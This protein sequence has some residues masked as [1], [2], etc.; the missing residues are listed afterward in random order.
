MLIKHLSHQL[1]D[2]E[3][4]PNNQLDLNNIGKRTFFLV[5]TIPLVEQQANVIEMQTNL[6]VGKF[7]G[8]EF[9]F[10]SKGQWIEEIKKYQVI[11]MI[12]EIFRLVIQH[13]FLPL[14]K[15]NLLIFDEAHHA[16][17][18]HPYREIMSYF[19]TCP[20]ENRPKILGLS[21]SLINSSISPDQLEEQIVKLEKTMRS[22]CDTSCD[23]ISLNKYAAKPKEVICYYQD[24]DVMD[25]SDEQIFDSINNIQALVDSDS[26]DN[27]DFFNKQVDV[28]KLKSIL[29]DV[30]F[31]LKSMGFWCGEKVAEFHIKELTDMNSNDISI[32]NY[33]ISCLTLFKNA[34]HNYL[35]TYDMRRKLIDFSSPKLRCLLNILKDYNESFE[36]QDDNLCAIIFVDRRSSS[37]ILTKWLFEISKVDPQY[38]FLKVEFVVGNSSSSLKIARSTLNNQKGI[39]EKFRTHQCNILAATSV[40]EEGL[41][42]P[43]CNLVIRYNFP[44]TCREYIQSKGRARAKNGAIVIMI[45]KQTSW[46]KKIRDFKNIELILSRNCH[47][48]R[49]P[50]EQECLQS[51]AEDALMEPYMP[52]KEDGA[53]RV[54]M[55]SA[56]A[57]I[58]KYCM[59]L[60]VVPSITLE[61]KYFTRKISDIPDLNE[62]NDQ[63]FICNLFL[64]VIIPIEKHEIVSLTMPSK[65]AA[66]KSAALLACKALHEAGQL[67]DNFM[68]VNR[69]M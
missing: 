63:Q 64:P 24:F 20:L 10:Y 36:R 53:P 44:K 41:D 59:K 35:S 1:K 69:K 22:R 46:L 38:N 60:P 37:S 12:H 68:P 61:P 67:D 40:L 25:L 32:I 55:N 6:K 5:P 50:T 13:G 14:S 58:N 33:V 43:H 29:G 19:D 65:M 49:P 42:V 52:I 11:V 47:M 21:A 31:N 28:D 45:E 27:I 66:K 62:N 18:N 51:F 48:R 26:D 7:H 17:K 39:L 57:L 4:N 16:A 23:I 15:V 34:I 9:D 3:I 30:L 2:P 56:I 8:E 54:T